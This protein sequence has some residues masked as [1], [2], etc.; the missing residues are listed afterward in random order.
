MALSC[1]LVGRQNY[2]RKEKKPFH[3]KSFNPEIMYLTAFYSIVA[4][5]LL[6]MSYTTRL[7]LNELI[8]SFD[9]DAKN[10]KVSGPIVIPSH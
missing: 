5:S 1:A 2:K 8:I 7:I 6:L 10:Y 9:K 3:L 4:G